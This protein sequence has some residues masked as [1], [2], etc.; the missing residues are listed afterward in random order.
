MAVRR[1]VRNLGEIDKLAVQCNTFNSVNDIRVGSI[2]FRQ[3]L[4]NSNYHHTGI[5]V[6]VDSAKGGFW[7][8]EGNGNKDEENSNPATSKVEL[9]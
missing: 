7:T 6:C 8:V 4:L 9:K 3:S 5:V 2:F 1:L